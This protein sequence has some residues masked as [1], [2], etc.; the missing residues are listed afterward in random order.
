MKRACLIILALSAV[1]LGAHAW[2][3][4][5]PV[6]LANRLAGHTLS[7]VTYLP[8]PPGSRGGGLA[9]IMLQA[10]LGAD[11]RTLVRV[12]DASRN[13]YTAP[14]ERRW[15]LSGSTLCIDLPSGAVPVCA[16]VHVW[17][18]RIDGVGTHPYAMLTGDLRPGN[19]ILPNR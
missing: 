7:A 1:G 11:G 6:P 4:D 17:G 10:Y 5:A 12:W 16:D 18:P 3:A 2:A 19:A 14:A 8:N 13:A 15:N 9:R